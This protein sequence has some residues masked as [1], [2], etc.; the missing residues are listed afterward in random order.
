MTFH[1][2]TP[3]GRLYNPTQ[4]TEPKKILLVDDDRDF[5]TVLGDRLKAE[6]FKT[7]VA[8]EGVRAIEVAH[9]TKPDLILLDLKMPAGEGLSV[10]ESL[11]KHP[12][13][14]PCPL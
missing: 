10:L 3:D 2:C 5:V 13:R 4:M 14:T 11:R 1:S 9:K 6:G 8:Y 12:D 7:V